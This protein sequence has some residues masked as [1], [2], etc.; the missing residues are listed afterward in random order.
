MNTE[1]ASHTPTP[2]FRDRLEGDLI[3]ALRQEARTG[4]RRPAL[5]RWQRLKQA[6]VLVVGLVL[7]VGTQLASAQV[8]DARTRSELESAI[9]I[10]MQVTALRLKIAQ[11][12]HERARRAFEAG[13]LSRQSLL[14]AASEMR[15]AEMAVARLSADLAE[16]RLSSTAPRNELY[17]PLIG[18]RDFVRERLMFEAHATQERLRNAEIALEEA[19]RNV[20]LGVAQPSAARDAE[21]EQ[22]RINKE[23]RL[24]AT[25]LQL[26]DEFL[27]KGLEVS[28][29]ARRLQQTEAMLDIQVVKQ[30]LV[31]AQE[32]LK[33]AQERASVG[34]A[35]QLDVKRAELELLSLQ[36]ELKRLSDMVGQWRWNPPGE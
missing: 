22:A 1:L 10:E 3:R 23:V 36:V 24:I 29:I 8:R 35:T 30:R 7:G 31:G 34:V 28:E 4:A 33:T 20:D 14:A 18:G 5:L 13:A 17:A 15:N 27:K 21:E 16:V 12:E 9:A 25:K 2:E 32:R 11:A 6:A 19:R 26:R